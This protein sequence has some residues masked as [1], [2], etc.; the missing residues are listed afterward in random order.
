MLR[1]AED[2]EVEEEEKEAEEERPQLHE[3]A[4]ILARINEASTKPRK[5]GL[6][7]NRK[8]M[9]R[10]LIA[11]QDTQIN[12]WRNNIGCQVNAYWCKRTTNQCVHGIVSLRKESLDSAKAY[13]GGSILTI[14]IFLRLDSLRYASRLIYFQHPPLSTTP[15]ATQ[16]Q[17]TRKEGHPFMLST[18]SLTLGQ[19]ERKRRRQ[20]HAH[21]NL[22]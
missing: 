9:R 19:D 10:E 1:R 6:V 15:V 20:T 3:H 22:I 17:V 21:L 4:A 11:P 5:R 13:F 12:V 8:K 18:F 16:Q 2:E 14:R 7:L